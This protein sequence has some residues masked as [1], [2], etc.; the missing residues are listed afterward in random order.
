MWKKV[1]HEL[2]DFL[3][4][5]YAVMKC[6]EL[7]FL[8]AYKKRIF[9]GDWLIV[10]SNKHQIEREIYAPPFRPKSEHGC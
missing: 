7:H 1:K 8:S 2:V 4:F 10:I 5:R 6:N 3:I 9:M